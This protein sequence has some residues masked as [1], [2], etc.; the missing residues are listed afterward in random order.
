MGRT[1]GGVS[2]HWDGIY[3]RRLPT[4]VSW[5]QDEPTVSLALL[6]ALDVIPQEAIVDVG[7]GA[8]VLVD[9]LLDRRFGDVSVLD[10]SASALAHAK[11]RL[12]TTIVVQIKVESRTQNAG[13]PAQRAD[14]RRRREVGDDLLDYPPP[15]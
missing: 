5:Y 11:E 7:G 2:G 13:E 3:G 15:A 6:D 8:S 1:A 14:A 9:R 10:V 4:E 12:E